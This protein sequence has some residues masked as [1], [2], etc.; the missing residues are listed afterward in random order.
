MKAQT[1][2]FDRVLTEVRSL[3]MIEDEGLHRFAAYCEM[4]RDPGCLPLKSRFY[5]EDVPDRL[6]Q[7]NLVEVL[8]EPFDYILRIAG[9]RLPIFAEQGLRGKSVDQITPHAYAL[10]LKKQFDEAREA[11]APSLRQITLTRGR[12]R[13][14][15]DHLVQPLS[16]NGDKVDYLVTT[17]S[18]LVIDDVFFH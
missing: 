2:R 12:R 16:I 14:S 18:K 8:Y 13:M 9:H 1:L 10:V 6:G 5:P 15:Y 7:L 4:I 3:E 17:T 11:C